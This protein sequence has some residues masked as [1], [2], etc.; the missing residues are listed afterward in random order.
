MSKV[1]LKFTERNKATLFMGSL[2]VSAQMT[3]IRLIFSDE[4]ALDTIEELLSIGKIQFIDV[5][6]RVLSHAL[7]LPFFLCFVLHRYLLLSPKCS[8]IF[9][10]VDTFYAINNHILFFTSFPAKRC[11]Q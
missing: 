5:S 2:L 4:A 3:H 11:V 8:T 7:P 6:F 1:A 10:F 9:L